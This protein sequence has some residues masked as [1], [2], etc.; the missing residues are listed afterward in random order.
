M[1]SSLAIVVWASFQASCKAVPLMLGRGKLKALTKVLFLCKAV[2]L[3]LGHG[4]LKAL[5]KGAIPVEHPPERRVICRA[6]LL[7]RSLATQANSPLSLWQRSGFLVVVPRRS[8][9]R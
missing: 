8:G 2:P 5:T 9:R 6:I 3:R 1:V 7:I 4:K